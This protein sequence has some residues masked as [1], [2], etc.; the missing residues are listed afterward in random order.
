MRKRFRE[1]DASFESRQSCACWR[2]GVVLADPVREDALM[3]G[4][5]LNQLSKV[6]GAA[7]ISEKK[8]I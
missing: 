6:V 4:I 3:N 5:E 2:G 1:C 8:S 7:H